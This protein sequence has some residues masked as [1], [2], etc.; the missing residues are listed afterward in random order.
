MPK[1]SAK[2]RGQ[3][4]RVSRGLPVGA[5]INCADN[6]GARLLRIV[7]VDGYK[8]RLRRLPSG[9]VGSMITVSVLKGPPEL[10]KKLVKAIIVRQRK[11][12]R[13]AD[14]TWVQFDDNAGIIV[15]PNGDPKG[16]DVRGPVAQEAIQRWPAMSGI[17]KVVV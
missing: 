2:R 15:E 11:P 14:G 16:S 6:T 13:R 17:A 1:K 10:R 7:Q 8:G 3:V 4:R 5:V 9:G 12:Y